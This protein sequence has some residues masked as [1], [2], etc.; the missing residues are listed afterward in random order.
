[1]TNAAFMW[2]GSLFGFRSPSARITWSMVTVTFCPDTV[3]LCPIGS[4]VFMESVRSPVSTTSI[5][6]TSDLSRSPIR[7]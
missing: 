5:G 1:M 6:G 4:G 3:S 7:Y 2:H